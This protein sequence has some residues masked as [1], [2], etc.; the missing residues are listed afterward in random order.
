MGQLVTYDIDK[1]S[2]GTFKLSFT[3]IKDTKVAYSYDATTNVNTITLTTG[4][5]NT[6]NFKKDF[7]SVNGKL[8]ITFN[9]S[10][11]ATQR[12]GGGPVIIIEDDDDGL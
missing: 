10:G 9:Q 2:K 12:A 1:K 6:T 4:S 8:Q 3:T 5:N 11:S 7:S